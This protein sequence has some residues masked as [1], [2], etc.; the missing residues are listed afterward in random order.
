MS[1][2]YHRC[3]DAERYPS[4]GVLVYVRVCVWCAR[5]DGGDDLHAGE[6]RLIF[7][8]GGFQVITTCP[9]DDPPVHHGGLLCCAVTCGPKREDGLSGRLGVAGL[10]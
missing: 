8:D 4:L 9:K 10:V 3:T 2:L 5:K 1:K 7:P 6:D